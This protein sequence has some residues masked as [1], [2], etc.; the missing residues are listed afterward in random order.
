MSKRHFFLFDFILP[1]AAILGIGRFLSG[2]FDTSLF[3]AL[4]KIKAFG[5]GAM[6]SHSP[7]RQ[8]LWDYSFVLFAAA[9]ALLWLIWVRINVEYDY[10]SRSKRLDRP[11]YGFF[12][13]LLKWIDGDDGLRWQIQSLE[14]R[15]A[16]SEDRARKLEAELMRTRQEVADLEKAN[17]DLEAELQGSYETDDAQATM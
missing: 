16:Q 15:A 4:D 13:S 11:L 5:F 14:F 9:P 10:L 1:I 3:M 8:V 6:F 2:Q 17:E 12:K 7:I